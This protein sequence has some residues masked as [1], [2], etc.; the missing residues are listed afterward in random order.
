MRTHKKL[1]LIA[2]A[3]LALGVA[4]PCF[5]VRDRLRSAEAIRRAIADPQHIKP[6]ELLERIDDNFM[7]MSD[8]ER[9]NILK[10]PVATENLIAAATIKELKKSFRLVFI[11]PESQRRA[12]IAKSAEDIRRKAR[13]NPEKVGE[14]Y[15]SPMGKGALRGA[16]KF[17]LFELSGMEK[18]ESAPLTKAMYEIVRDQ[19]L[20]KRGQQ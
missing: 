1:L 13:L 19:S 4:A 17:F 20:K 8:S 2:L 9:D 15:D 3:L 5:W 7:G 6:E 18:A 16:S 11:L 10:D 14:L 12:V